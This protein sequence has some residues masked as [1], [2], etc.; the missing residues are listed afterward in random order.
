MFDVIS[1]KA[2]E[3]AEDVDVRRGRGDVL[4]HRRDAVEGEVVEVAGEAEGY[5][6]RRGGGHQ[7][8]DSVREEE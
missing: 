1:L 8:F 2:A 4:H 3:D 7:S 5:A 6:G